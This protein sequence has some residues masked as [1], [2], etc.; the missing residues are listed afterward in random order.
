MHEETETE[1]EVVLE[2]KVN[3]QDTTRLGMRTETI[4]NLLN[5]DV[6]ESYVDHEMVRIN[7]LNAEQEE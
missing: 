2:P 4:Q 7:S 3:K 6:W 1:E 5:L